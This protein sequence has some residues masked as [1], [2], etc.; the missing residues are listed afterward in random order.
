MEDILF[1]EL[2][3]ILSKNQ[4]NLFQEVNTSALNSRLPTEQ[5]SIVKV[6]NQLWSVFYDSIKILCY[7]ICVVVAKVCGSLYVEMRGLCKLNGMVCGQW[8]CECVMG[9][10]FRW[11]LQISTQLSPQVKRFLSRL[12]LV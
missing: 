3:G 9:G 6:L 5:S 12:V 2:A 1:N 10:V 11:D 8:V 4:K 7:G